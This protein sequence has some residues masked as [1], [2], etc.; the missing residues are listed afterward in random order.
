MRL[1]ANQI[2]TYVGGRE[3]VAP[4]DEHRIITGL[5]W[6]SREVQEGF[7]YVALPGAR[8]D[9]HDFVRQAL[10]SGAGLVLVSHEL[11]QDAYDL[12]REKGTGVFQV[13][14]TYA[15]VTD[16]ARG[17]RGHLTGRVIALTGSVGKT[18]TK[19]LVRD[20]LSTTYSVW[21]TKANQNN[22]LGVPKTL[23]DADEDT[24][25]VIVEM[26][27]RGKGQ[28]ASLCEFVKPDLALVTNCGEC[29]IELLGSHE[30]IAQAKAE[31]VAA[32]AD[33]T[34]VAVLNLDDERLD[35]VK[36][37]ARVAERGI[38]VVGFDGAGLHPEQAQAWASE[39]SLDAQGRPHFVL[40]LPDGARELTLGLRGAHNVSNACA[41]AALAYEVGVP[42]DAIVRGLEGAKP[43]G[44]RQEVLAGKNG[45]IVINDAYN[46]NP[47]SMK[48]ALSMFCAMEV[49]GRRFAVLGDMGELGDF[50]KAGHEGVGAFV[51]TQPIDRLLCIGELAR[52]IADAA[53]KEGYPASRVSCFATRREAL[54]LLES[55][56]TSGDAVLCKASHSMQLDKIAK[57]LT[58]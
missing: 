30:A 43:E 19:N 36:D 42:G 47:D 25:F 9:G 38:K 29:H 53:I 34:G 3:L 33:G 46:A 49:S 15:A 21:A 31:P 16:L 54:D 11:A 7:V 40:H 51:A 24:Q 14:D 28:L 4:A 48:A 58:D 2:N 23:L 45:V 1:N 5:A 17:W 39:V 55:E 6:D 56:L 57:E 35:I 41:A 50:A 10:Q 37:F 52:D 12:A 26:G 22:E 8:V 32:L 44:G 20:V 18:T 27:M 13:A